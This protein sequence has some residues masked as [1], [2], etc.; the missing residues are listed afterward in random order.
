MIEVERRS[1]RWN[2]LLRDAH[3]AWQR[4]HG[5]M[6]KRWSCV[7]VAPTAS[8]SAVAALSR[9][10]PARCRGG[11]FW[12]STFRL[13]PYLATL[14]VSWFAADVYLEQ[15]EQALL[16]RCSRQLARAVQPVPMKCGDASGR[17]PCSRERQC[18]GIS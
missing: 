2:A 17:L 10:L 9:S 7:T 13:T 8:T 11:Y 6:R 15:R 16:A 3:K 18:G 14:A 12:L 1:D 5:D 4:A